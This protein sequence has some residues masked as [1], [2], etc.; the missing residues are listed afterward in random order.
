MAA[1]TEVRRLPAIVSRLE[2]V[3]GPDRHV[4]LFLEIAVHIAEPHVEGAVRV[5]VEAFVHWGDALTAPVPGRHGRLRLRRDG[6]QERGRANQ[7]DECSSAHMQIPFGRIV[8]LSAAGFRLAHQR[9]A[10]NSSPRNATTKSRRH[11]ERTKDMV[12]F[13]VSCLRGKK[14]SNHQ[15]C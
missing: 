3:V 5:D 4:D 8:W 1:R 7:R 9:H 15:R 10:V 6:D 2:P 14:C 11:E 12:F 13:V